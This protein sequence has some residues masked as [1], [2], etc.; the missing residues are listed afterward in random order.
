MEMGMTPEVMYGQNVFV[1]ATANPYQY[2]YA[3]VGSPMEWYNHPSSLGYDGQDIYYPAEGM[4]CVYYAAP[5][6]GSMH[7]T[8]SPYPSDPSFVPDGSFMPQE[9][10]ADPANSTCQ[11][12]PT[13]YY[14][15]AVLP[16][17][18]DGVPGSATTPL[19]SSNV[20]FLP[21]IPG[22]AATSANAA[23]PLIA[24]VTSKSD[25]VMH[26]PVHSS[27]VPSKQFQDH[28]KP[29]KVQLHNSVP[30]KQELPDRCMV[31]AK[32]P[33]TSQVSAHLSGNNCLGCAAGSDLQKWAAAEKFQPSS[34]SSGH[35]NGTGQKVHSLVDSEK[36]S[37]QS[38]AIIVKS[39]TSR[40]VVGNPDGTIIIRTDQYNRDDLRIDYTYAK[41][42][43]I[44]SI[45]EADV[46]KSIKYGVW[47]SSSNGNSKLDSAFRDADRISRRH[48]TKCPVFLFFSVNGSGHFCGMAEMVGPVDFH[49]DMDFWCQDKWTGC[50]P[51]RWHVVKDIQN[52]SLQHIT[53]QNNEN[54]PVTHSRDTQ[55][56]PY[57]PGI[58]MIEIF[59]GIKA[60]FC[61]FDDFMRYEAEEAQKKTHRRCKLSYN[62]PDFVPV[63]QRTKDAFDTQQTKSSSVLVDR[64][65]EIQ[66]VAEKPHDAK[67]IIKPQEPCVC[68]K[69]AS[70]AEKENGVQES[71]CSGNQS[72]EDAAK[73]VTNHPPASSL[74]AG[75]EGKQ[76]YWKKVENPK[77][78]ADSGAAQGLLKAPEK[79]LNGVSGTVSAVPEGGE[80][81]RVFAKLGSLKISSKAVEADH[82]TSTVG[83]EKRLNGVSGSA[84]AVPQGG[85]EQRVTAKLSSLKIGSKAVEADRKINTVGVVT[86]GS[87]PV[88][89]DSCDV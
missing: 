43:V 88:R 32:L 21:G 29:P 55:E 15:P 35:L 51:V 75:A 61:L 71:H 64:T 19:H 81:Q 72:Q 33:H 8:Y 82:K 16:Y 38:S 23:F 27:I 24:P 89:V 87:M 5:D 44:K 31:P 62:A 53:L 1:P 58:S 36:P 79:R 76:Q 60:R 84:S 6:S 54:K 37:N 2:G 52:C 78:H 12:A 46:H 3:E 67:A 28:A 20:A 42:F 49:K 26:P 65:S 14:I 70:E 4:Q 41:F 57:L 80:E 83:V 74:K 40:L 45:G 56:I 34:K 11:I 30:Q 10:V 25:I 39:Y 59:K 13:S 17:A 50:F 7:P 63:S 77:Q 86:I 48:S 18:Q 47:S 22:Y 68:E 73:T 66:N 69:Q 9:Y 85:V